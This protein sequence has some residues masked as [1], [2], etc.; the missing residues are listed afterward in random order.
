MHN[1]LQEYLRVR[2]FDKD[3]GKLLENRVFDDLHR[4]HGRVIFVKGRGRDLDFVAGSRAI[5]V[6]YELNDRSLRR[7]AEGATRGLELPAVRE[8]LVVVQEPMEPTATIAG[9]QVLPYWR[10]SIEGIL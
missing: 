2:G 1:L 7:K 5:Q 10:A 4:R 6:S 8:S 9:V 3:W